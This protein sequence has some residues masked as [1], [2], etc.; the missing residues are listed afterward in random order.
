MI[1]RRAQKTDAN[2]KEIVEALRK[3]GASVEF[4]GKPVDLVIGYCGVN[5]LVEVKDGSKPPSHQK[6]TPDQVKFID[7]WR[8]TVFIV[9]SIDDALAIIKSIQDKK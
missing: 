6:L 7:A 9:K 3:A 4:I 2:Q 8:G 5:I 1:N